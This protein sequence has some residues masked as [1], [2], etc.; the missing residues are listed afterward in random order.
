MTPSPQ[1]AK[2]MK[3]K[4]PEKVFCTE[5]IPMANNKL[6]GRECYRQTSASDPLRFFWMC[7]THGREKLLSEPY[8]EIA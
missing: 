3:A 2:T 7:P 5:P 8:E 1:E 6:C 4:L